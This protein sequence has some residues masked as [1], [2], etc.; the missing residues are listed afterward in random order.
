MDQLRVD[1]SQL[2]QQVALL[3]A[4]VAQMQAVRPCHKCLVAVPVKFDGSLAHFP[5]FFGQCQLYMSLRTLDDASVDPAQPG[6]PIWAQTA[7]R[8]LRQLKQGHGLLMDYIA[9]FQVV[10]QDLQWNEAAL[11]DQFQEGL[12]ELLDELAC[13]ECPCTLQEL[14]HMCLCIDARLQQQWAKTMPLVEVP[15]EEPMQMGAAHPRLTQVEKDRHHHDGLCLYCGNRGHF[16]AKCPA[17]TPTAAMS[18]SKVLRPAILA[19]FTIFAIFTITAML[20]IFD[21]FDISIPVVIAVV[22]IQ[23][24]VDSGDMANFMD[25]HF[26]KQWFTPQQQMSPPVMVE[27]IDGQP[28][29][30][31]L[32]LL[33]P[34]PFTCV[35]GSM[36]RKLC[37]M[38]PQFLILQWCWVWSGYGPMI[39]RSSGHL[40]IWSWG[41]AI[42]VDLDLPAE[43]VDFADQLPLHQSYDCPI[44][45]LPEAKLPVGRIYSLS[46]PELAALQDFIEKNLQKGFI[47]PSTSLLAAPVLLFIKKKL[48]ELHLCCDYRKLNVITVLNRYLLPL[49]PELIE[50][51]RQAKIFRKL[52]LHGAYN[53]V[54]IRAGDKWKMAFRTRYGHFEY[55]VISF[56]LTNAPAVFMHF[57]HD[58]FHDLLD[59]LVVIYLNDILIYSASLQEHW[60]HVRLVLQRLR[61]NHLFAKCGKCQFAQT[62]IDFLG[63]RIS[64]AGVEMDPEKVESLQAWEPP[65]Q[66]KDKFHWGAEE[67]AAFDALKVAFASEPILKDPDPFQPFVVETDASEVAVGGSHRYLVPLR[68]SFLEVVSSRAQLYDL[69][70]GAIGGGSS[71][72]QDSDGS[73]QFGTPTY[74]SDIEP[75]SVTYVLSGWN[76]CVNALSRKLEYTQREDKILPWTVIPLEQFAA[77]EEPDPFVPAQCGELDENGRQETPW[78]SVLFMALFYVNVMIV[79][80]QDTLGCSKC[81]TSLLGHFGGQD[82]SMTF[83][84]MPSLLLVCSLVSCSQYPCQKD[85]GGSLIGLTELPPLK[86]A[87]T[88]LVVVDMLTKMAHFIPC[89]GLPTARITTQL[90]I[91]HIFRLHKLPNRI[92]SDWGV[93]FTARFWQTLLVELQVQVCLLSAHHPKT[94]GGDRESGCYF[95][96]VPPLFQQDNWVEVLPVAEFAYNN[97]QHASTRVSPFFANYGFHPRL[98]PLAQSDSPVPAVDAFLQELKAMHQMVQDQLKRAKEDYKCFAD[99]HCHDVPPLV[100]GNRVWLSTRYLPTIRGG[101]QSCGF[102]PL[103]A[104]DHSVFHRSLLVPVLADSPHRPAPPPLGPVAPQGE[105]EY[106]YLMAWKGYGPEDF[107][108]VDATDVHA[109]RLVHDFH[110]Q[111]PQRPRLPGP[112]GGGPAGGDSV[113]PLGETW[114]PREERA[115]ILFMGYRC[116]IQS[117]EANPGV[118]TQ[119]GLLTAVAARAVAAAV[120]QWWQPRLPQES[121]LNWGWWRQQHVGDWGLQSLTHLGR[122]WQTAGSNE[123]RRGRVGGVRMQSTCRTCA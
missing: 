81:C 21:I 63:H 32:W 85:L 37:F 33:Q 12:S 53:L 75:A 16:V 45:L 106:E 62:T 109:P 99:R 83:Q 6:D 71:P 72:D 105:A 59:Q 56:G 114:S 123:I 44:D 122:S 8:H 68:L 39:H 14:M 98:F 11:L 50:R 84:D 79:W 73:S 51:L 22:E 91:S 117:L 96:A 104:T 118:R 120:A 113:M 17:K 121:G 47:R 111:F 25:T 100:I 119:P 108:W 49:I 26:V 13:T 46:E 35:L 89:A 57:M 24:L 41:V 20:I 48:G 74:S 1:N 52:D 80:H 19:I 101:D 23:A 97:A 82:L 30:L 54:C 18:G 86:G 107:T 94:D 36:W 65:Q 61:D 31:G 78:G 103:P 42:P 4:Q 77:T 10:T 3:T 7:N 102:L 27:T 90:F 29:R 115:L 112:G 110:T 43:L 15:L 66:V 88:I 28:L 2:S 55:P 60:Q 38:L 93:Q 76:Q 95:G 9:S 87:T 58:I 70:Q 116:D 64:P 92:V 40:V 34:N 5:A 67:Q 69:G